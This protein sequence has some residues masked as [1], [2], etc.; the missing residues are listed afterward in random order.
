MPAVTEIRMAAATMMM[1]AGMTNLGQRGTVTWRPPPE[2]VPGT[3][4]ATGF[5][6]H[7]PDS[8]ATYRQ[9]RVVPAT[10]PRRRL[11]G[12]SNERSAARNRLAR[13]ERRQRGKRPAQRAD[14]DQ[15]QPGGHRAGG[16]GA[17]SCRGQ[18]HR[19]TGRPGGRHLLLYPPDRVNVAID[20]DFS[21]ARDELAA[22]QVRGRELVDDSER[23]H[24]PGAR[25]SD[26]PDVDRH[27][28]R[29]SE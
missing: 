1:T 12:G 22:S 19:R 8:H 18:E 25:S 26:V 21:G 6:L 13:L 24:Q 15:S 27:L 4:K 23:E 5:S 2:C 9:A 20:L 3:R 10:I 17:V 16:I 7:K 29:E 11:I 14:L 28:E